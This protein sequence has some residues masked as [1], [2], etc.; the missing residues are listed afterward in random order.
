MFRDE[1]DAFAVIE[2]VS[3]PE[4]SKAP[5]QDE[6]GSEADEHPDHTGDRARRTDITRKYSQ[7]CNSNFEKM[8]SVKR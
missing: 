5:L 1:R 3:E 6:V 2:S 4:E 8:R 7:L